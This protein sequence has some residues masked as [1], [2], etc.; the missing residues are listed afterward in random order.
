MGMA[1]RQKGVKATRMGNA[2]TPYLAALGSRR[3]S[4]SVDIALLAPR[5]RV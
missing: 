3:S 5:A 2:V 4:R 1:V